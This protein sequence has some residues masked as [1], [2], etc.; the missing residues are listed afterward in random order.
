M[1]IKSI[2]YEFLL[3]HDLHDK[4]ALCW[5][6][7]NAPLYD[8]LLCH[9]LHD[10]LCP[11]TIDHDNKVC[12]MLCRWFGLTAPLFSRY[13]P[14]LTCSG[15]AGAHRRWAPARERIEKHKVGKKSWNVIDQGT[16]LEEM[17]I[18]RDIVR[19]QTHT[20]WRWI[21]YQSTYRVLLLL[22][23]HVPRLSLSNFKFPF[24]TRASGSAFR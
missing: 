8:V 13:T 2:L 17:Q 22:L 23:P 1:P 12:V 14:L 19:L 3:R 11:T 20:N 21:N 15:V 18:A 16:A 6:G 5:F 10:V 7:R 9:D 24:A 4:Y